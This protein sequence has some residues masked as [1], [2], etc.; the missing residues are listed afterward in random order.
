MKI[1]P[2][3]KV[4]IDQKNNGCRIHIKFDHSLFI[5]DILVNFFVVGIFWL[6]ASFAIYA[7]FFGSDSGAVGFLMVWLIGVSV[8]TY[9]AISHTLW[10]RKGSETL[11]LDDDKILIIKH[12]PLYFLTKNYEDS[13]TILFENLEKMYYS[14]YS[15]PKNQLPSA[16]KGNLHIKSKFKK[17][18]FG[19]SLNQQEASLIFDEITKFKD[20]NLD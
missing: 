9:H 12:I 17:I 19:I 4:T 16:A 2:D 13:T 1:Q 11:D 20:K 3:S 6:A 18:S 14:E 7:V 10:L 15:A 8:F 5:G